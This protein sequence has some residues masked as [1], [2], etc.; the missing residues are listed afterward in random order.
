[1]TQTL[2]QKYIDKILSKNSD[3]PMYDERNIDFLESLGLDELAK[4][5]YYQEEMEVEFDLKGE[6]MDVDFDE[7]EL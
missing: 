5:A 3:D 1:M 7:E 6:V 2:R 4:L